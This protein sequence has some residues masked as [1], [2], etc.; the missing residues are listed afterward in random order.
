MN[1]IRRIGA[2]LLFWLLMLCELGPPVALQEVAKDSLA[3]PEEAIWSRCAESIDWYA[4][5]DTP[6]TESELMTLVLS[7]GLEAHSKE[8]IQGGL[9]GLPP[10]GEWLAEAKRRREPIF[11][12]VTAVEGQHMI[13]PHLQDRYFEIGALSDPTLSA[14]I[15]RRFLAVKAPA[16]GGLAKQFGLTSPD[17]LQPGLIVIDP[18][19]ELVMKLDRCSVFSPEPYLDLLREV[20]ESSKGLAPSQQLE[21][22]RRRWRA[23]KTGA[24]WLRLANEHYLDGD[25][26]AA[27]AMA[28]EHLEQEGDSAE[29]LLVLA[30]DA[31]IRQDAVLA[32]G[33]LTRA[34]KVAGSRTPSIDVEHGLV[35]MRLGDFNLAE[36]HFDAALKAQGS[37]AAEAGYFLG[38]VRYLSAREELALG[39]WRQTL[40]SFPDSI[41]SARAAAYLR[42][43]TDGLRG[44]GPLTRSMESVLWTTAPP[45]R[46]GA[47]QGH[48]SEDLQG[49][50][51]NAVEFLL[52]QQR[53]DGSWHGSRWG[54]GGGAAPLKP[55]GEGPGL[56]GNIHTAISALACS[57]LLACS[58]FP[59]LPGDRISE[60]L[61]RGERYLLRSDLVQRG[62]VTAWVYADAFRLGY[63]ASRYPERQACPREVKLQMQGWV[64]QLIMQ[65]DALGGPFRHYSYNSTFVTAMVM[66]MLDRARAAGCEVPEFVF[67][68]GSQV[69]EASREGDQG[70]FGYLTNAPGVNRTLAGAAC[71]QLLCTLALLKSGRTDRS[72]V[73]DALELFC[74]NYRTL[75]E[76]PRL[77]NFHMPELDG[78]A[79]YYFFHNFLA[80]SM[81]TRVVGERGREFYVRLRQFLF[82]LPDVDGTF[83]DAGFSYGKSYGTAMAL[84]ALCE[85]EASQ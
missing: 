52:M 80:A 50:V 44:E 61:E 6:D 18:N 74:D 71:R 85:L 11:W 76:P 72:D 33:F 20:L 23:D 78:S 45:A 21:R 13:L 73:V 12:W 7:S 32:R 14:L 26:G 64:D 35:A 27:A 51:S 70:L 56:F 49:L 62:D 24:H 63:F 5:V 54:A 59:D 75:I 69:L 8:W 42:V 82:E 3:V 31:R 15:N 28:H 55:I 46:P 41:W 22:E 29:A 39:A 83:L 43:G 34:E 65:Q 9:K 16:G 67:E 40:Q 1:G 84:L 37:R 38:A 79:G 58:R 19:G 36:R 68:A 4:R 48:T 47:G 30:R 2:F 53:S 10:Y 66:L 77:S 81:A 17:F 60:A 57:A 25:L